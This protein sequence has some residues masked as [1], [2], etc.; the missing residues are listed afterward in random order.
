MR[1]P[2][3]DKYY[4]LFGQRLV[5]YTLKEGVKEVLIESGLEYLIEEDVEGHKSKNISV[6]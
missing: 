4:S 3:K 2:E 5:P 1:F 6:S